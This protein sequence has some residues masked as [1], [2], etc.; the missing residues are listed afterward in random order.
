[1]PEEE[2]H[3][4]ETQIW[5]EFILTQWDKEIQPEEK[6]SHPELPGNV[7]GSIKICPQLEEFW[8]F[9]LGRSQKRMAGRK[10]WGGTGGCRRGTVALSLS[11]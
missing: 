9:Y 11:P 4:R 2:Q 8:L 10:M 6:N 1:V 7:I 3:W 5:K